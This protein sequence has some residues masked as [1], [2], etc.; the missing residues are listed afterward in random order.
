[1]QGSKNPLPFL[2]DHFNNIVD[3]E[4]GKRIGL[5]IYFLAATHPELFQ[6]KEGARLRTSIAE[7]GANLLHLE[8]SR[9]IARASSTATEATVLRVHSNP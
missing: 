1:M 6:G 8:G 2:I 4:E 3:D 5:M 7:I 9:V